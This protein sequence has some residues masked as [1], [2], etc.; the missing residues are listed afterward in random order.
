MKTFK[1]GGNNYVVR[2]LDY[3]ETYEAHSVACVFQ[4]SERKTYIKHLK[5]GGL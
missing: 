3:A 5:A 4:Y 2:V 1:A